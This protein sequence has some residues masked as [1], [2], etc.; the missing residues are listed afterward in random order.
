M[1]LGPLITVRR[2]Q[3]RREGGPPSPVKKANEIDLR[4]RK[5]EKR[6]F[7]AP[8]HS[9]GRK[10]FPP[11]FF[12]YYAYSFILFGVS[13]SGTFFSE[14]PLPSWTYEKRNVQTHSLVPYSNPNP[15]K[16]L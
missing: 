3:D 13:K 6:T 9:L 5:K 14:A 10:P 1:Y 11:L 4:A 7:F 2:L 15:K 12:F 8:S 16:V